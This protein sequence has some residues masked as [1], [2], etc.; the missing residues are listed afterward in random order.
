PYADG[1]SWLVGDPHMKISFASAMIAALLPSPLFPAAAQTAPF[2]PSS[3]QKAEAVLQQMTLDEKIGQLNLSAGIVAPGIANEKP[4]QPIIEGKVGSILW[5][6]DVK[7][8][9]RL[10]KLA[11]EQARV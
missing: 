2:S 8:I 1:R 5:L 11:V 7:E 4:D 10:Q 6:I 9:N 3:R